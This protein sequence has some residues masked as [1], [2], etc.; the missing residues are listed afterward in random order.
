MFTISPQTYP[1]LSQQIEGDA[2]DAHAGDEFILNGTTFP[3]VRRLHTDKGMVVLVAKTQVRIAVQKSYEAE[4]AD[5]QNSLN[6]KVEGGEAS[7]VDLMLANDA[8][9]KLADKL[10]TD[11]G[12]RLENDYGFIAKAE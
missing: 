4:A 2:R 3:V 5:I 12:E 10:Q 7:E 1:N 8:M 9:G 11:V 6:A